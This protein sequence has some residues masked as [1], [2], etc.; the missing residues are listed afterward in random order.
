MQYDDIKSWYEL[1]LQNEKLESMLALMNDMD[2]DGASEYFTDPFT[3]NGSE[4]THENLRELIAGRKS[5]NWDA[6]SMIPIHN[7]D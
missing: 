2:A 5:Q 1:E 6:W 7:L 3:F 4:V